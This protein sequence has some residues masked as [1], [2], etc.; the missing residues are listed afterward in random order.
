L[1]DISVTIYSP[2]AISIYNYRRQKHNT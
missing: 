2:N 1:A